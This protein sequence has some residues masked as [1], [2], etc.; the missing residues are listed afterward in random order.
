MPFKKL[1]K[2]ARKRVKKL[3]PKEIR[4]FIPYI[5]AAMGPAGLA[6]SGIFS[7]PA[8]TKALIAGG[9]RF[10]TDDEADLKDIGITDIVE[11][12]YIGFCIFSI[13]FKLLPGGQ[14]YMLL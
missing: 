8:V 13:F 3:I 12:R 14:L 5:A 6:S 9:T 7:N 2:S 10:A 4:P 11:I 1:F